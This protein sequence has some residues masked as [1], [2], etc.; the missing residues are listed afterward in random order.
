MKKLETFYSI[1]FRGKSHFENDG[2]QNYLVF[3]RVCRYFKA[4]S[5]T[6]SNIS[7]WKSKGLYDESIRPPT[8]SDNML[9]L[10]VDYVGNKTREKFNGDCLKQ[11][12]ST[13]NHG[14]IVNI[15]S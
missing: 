11:K 6:E 1:Y 13:F 9:N 3:Q 10:S 7:S 4:V 12:K 5:A 14:K 8:T 15:S 2:I